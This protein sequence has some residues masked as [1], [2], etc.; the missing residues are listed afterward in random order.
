VY[1]R[2]LCTR[3]RD[4]QS[5]L[6]AYCLQAATIQSLKP[7]RS[8]PVDTQATNACKVSCNRCMHTNNTPHCMHAGMQL[9][10]YVRLADAIEDL[11]R[12][13]LEMYSN[14]RH[15]VR[16][17]MCCTPEIQLQAALQRLPLSQAAWAIF[18]TRR[19]MRK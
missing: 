19:V 12:L 1:A 2:D 3:Q 15:Y 18:C 10:S 11:E 14:I 16:R 9:R 6:V 13:H 8:A 4:R 5:N 17:R 7:S